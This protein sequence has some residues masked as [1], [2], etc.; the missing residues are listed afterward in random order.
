MTPRGRGSVASCVSEM[1]MERMGRYSLSLSLSP[2]LSL[3]ISLLSWFCMQI[4]S[5]GFAGV[6]YEGE[7]TDEDAL[8][9]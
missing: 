1:Q 3:S 9:P 6:Q 5:D 7:W 2:S 8:W 4:G